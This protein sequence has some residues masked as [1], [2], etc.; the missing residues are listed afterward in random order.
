[1]TTKDRKHEGELSEQ[2]LDGVAGGQQVVNMG[3]ITVE[4][5]RPAPK[6]EVVKMDTIVVTAQRDKPD[7]AGVRVAGVDS[8]TRKN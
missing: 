5:K 3:K 1:M 7:A 8:K 2:Q 6:Q 4:A